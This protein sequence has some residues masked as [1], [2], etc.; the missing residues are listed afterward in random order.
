MEEMYWKSNKG[1]AVIIG[2]A[3]STKQGKS[4]VGRIKLNKI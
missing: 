4:K 2:A 3:F 1:E